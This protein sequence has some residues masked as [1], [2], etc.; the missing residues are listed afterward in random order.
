VDRRAFV[1]TF[2]L[3]LLAAPLAA[4]AQPAGRSARVGFL[5]P[6][7]GSTFESDERR[8]YREAFSGRL[9]DLAWTEGQNVVIDSRY[10]DGD[11][12]GARPHHPAVAAGAGGSGD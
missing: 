12:E 6:S 11:R 5:T 1:S 10:A 9:R 8:V 3:G 4:E 7:S 2:A